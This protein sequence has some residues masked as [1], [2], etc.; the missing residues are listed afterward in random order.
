MNMPN[1]PS[2][3]GSG[4]SSMSDF[5]FDSSPISNSGN[6]GSDEKELLKLILDVDDV[7][8]NF[9]HRVL[10]GE[11][12]KINNKTYVE[13]WEKPIDCKPPV[14]EIG[15]REIMARLIGRVTKAAKLT[16]KEDEECYKDMFHLDMSL[17]EL[18]AKRC[19]TWEMNLETMKSIK[20][21]CLE[22]IEDIVFS[23]R[24]GFTAINLKS[25]YSR[26]DVSRSEGGTQ[27]QRSFLGI[28]LGRK[29]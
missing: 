7:L 2:M 6:S 27:Q 25:Q 13:Y 12:R 23:S 18:F 8:E 9:E 4:S 14:N 21:S 5:D 24:S 22:V 26:S 1:S 3:G 15:V 28:P 11:I 17:S 19:D 10:R 29:K 16:Y 20:D